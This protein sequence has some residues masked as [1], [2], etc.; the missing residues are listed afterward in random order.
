MLLTADAMADTADVA[1][2]AETNPLNRLLANLRDMQNEALTSERFADAADIQKPIVTVLEALDRGRG[3]TM[4]V[5]TATRNSMQRLHRAARNRGE[6]WLAN[7]YRAYVDD[8][9]LLLQ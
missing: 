3:V 7:V 1:G 5:T 4:E 2:T 6:Q 9:R 8:F